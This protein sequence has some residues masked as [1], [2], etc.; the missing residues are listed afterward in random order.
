MSEQGTQFKKSLSATATEVANFKALSK[1]E[2]GNLYAAVNKAKEIMENDPKWSDLIGDDLA[3][4]RRNLAVLN[5]Q[6][7]SL[8]KVA[9]NVINLVEEIT[10]KVDR[11]GSM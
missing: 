11:F 9:D 2:D 8:P 1:I 4:L 7:K 5:K 3:S 6:Y 10:Q